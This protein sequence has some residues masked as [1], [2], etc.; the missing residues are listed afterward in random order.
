MSKE[1][2]IAKLRVMFSDPDHDATTRIPYIQFNKS[3]LCKRTPPK[4]KAADYVLKIL[5]ESCTAALQNG[6]MKVLLFVCAMF[7]VAAQHPEQ[8]RW[9]QGIMAVS[10]STAEQI[11][12]CH[13]L[14]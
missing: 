3:S 6:Q 7:L 12:H 9:P 1:F 2:D 14:S 4:R 8:M 13:L 10:V 11:L 5:T